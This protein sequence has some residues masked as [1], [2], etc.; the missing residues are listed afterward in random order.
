MAATEIQSDT[1]A[2]SSKGRGAAGRGMAP[3]WERARHR[4]LARRLRTGDLLGA[5][6]ASARP[7]FAGYSCFR[8]TPQPM[9]AGVVGAVTG[10]GSWATM[11]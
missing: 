6:P 2:E 9:R 10:S 7:C 4:A 8:M 1:R 5:S 3:I 11:T